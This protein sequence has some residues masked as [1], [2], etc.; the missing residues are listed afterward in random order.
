M[1]EQRDPNPGG[2]RP[3]PDEYRRKLKEELKIELLKEI[4]AE[5]KSERVDA[6]KGTVAHTK[7]H[8]PKEEV[9]PAAPVAAEPS[10]TTQA[11]PA[12]PAASTP[13][14]RITLSAKA[15]LKLASH[16]LKY[17]NKN[18]PREKWVE[19]IGLLAGRLDKDELVLQ[20]E[21]A[22][23]MGHGNAV[24][25]EIKEYKNFVRA[26]NDLRSQGLFVCGW[27]HSHPSYGLFLSE[28]DMGTQ[29]RYQKLWDKSIALVIDPYLIDGTS[30][31][32]NIFRANLK[33]R[34]WFPVPFSFKNELDV[35]IL[36]ELVEF[37]NPIVD[38]KSL[39]LEYDSSG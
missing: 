10:A 8:S 4:Y 21:E 7:E 11:P 13:Q 6:A 3:D 23:P 2:D 19:V 30:F 16:A 39:F 37:I 9:P 35:K 17:A 22:Y 29:A 31:G 20:V 12:L 38:G 32:F 24:Y 18:I 28:E 34:K 25:A 36:P 15:F 27:Y 33:T 26:Y 14:E 5:L 1:A